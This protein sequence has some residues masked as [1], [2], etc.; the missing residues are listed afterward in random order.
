MVSEIAATLK[1]VVS[2]RYS[3]RLKAIASLQTTQAAN[4]N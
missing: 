2:K 3:A 1:L 4:E